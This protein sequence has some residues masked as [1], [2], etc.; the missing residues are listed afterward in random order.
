MLEWEN[1]DEKAEVGGRRGECV[2]DRS[3]KGPGTDVRFVNDADSGEGRE[4]DEANAPGGMGERAKP[5]DVPPMGPDGGGPMGS[6]RGD[7]AI[8]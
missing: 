3:D 7:E 4:G 8:R 2:L 5:G 6:R 1:E